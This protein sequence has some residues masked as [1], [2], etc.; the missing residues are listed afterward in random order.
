MAICSLFLIFCSP[1]LCKQG[2]LLCQSKSQQLLE[3]MMQKDREWDSK[4]FQGTPLPRDCSRLWESSVPL[5]V[6]RML[7]GEVTSSDTSHPPSAL[8]SQLNNSLWDLASCVSVAQTCSVVKKQLSAA[9]GSS[10]RLVPNRLLRIHD[11]DKKSCSLVNA[12]SPK[13]YFKVD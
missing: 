1:F 7:K 2:E 9:Y 13:W 3:V 8:T 12:S 6:S 11:L 5:L 4:L 10:L